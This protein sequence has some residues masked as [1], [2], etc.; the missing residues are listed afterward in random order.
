M[1]SIEIRP[2]SRSDREQLTELVNVHVDAVV[3]GRSVSVNAVLASSSVS[4]VSS[5]STRG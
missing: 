3:P 4:R 5:S 2:F 1:S